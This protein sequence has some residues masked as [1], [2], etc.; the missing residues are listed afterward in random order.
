[1]MNAGYKLQPTS[2]RLFVNGQHHHNM[3]WFLGLVKYISQFLPNISAYTTPLSGMCVNGLP[4]IWR[5]AHNKCF[6]TI[7]AIASKKTHLMSYQPNQQWPCLGSMWHVP[8]RL[9]GILRSRWRLENHEA[10]RLYVQE[11]HWRAMLILHIW[12]RDLRSN[13][14]TQKVGQW[15]PEIRIITDHEALKTFMLK[16]HSRPCQI[17]WS[18]WFSQ[19]RLKFIHIPGSHN[20]VLMHYHDYSKTQIVKCD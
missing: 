15:T 18:Q 19:Y 10:C 20:G 4:F 7:K 12:A 11:I 6:E 16:A 14:S 5:G 13:W 1:M 17:C 3:Q 2:W 8:F 9:Q